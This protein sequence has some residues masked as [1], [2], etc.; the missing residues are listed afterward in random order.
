MTRRVFLQTLVWPLWFTYD[1][2]VADS[3]DYWACTSWPSV[4]NLVGLTNIAICHVAVLRTVS[5]DV[6]VSDIKLLARSGAVWVYNA[7]LSYQ[8]NTKQLQLAVTSR[9]ATCWSKLKTTSLALPVT[10]SSRWSRILPGHVDAFWLR[11]TRCVC[12]EGKVTALI[13]F[14]SPS[15]AQKRQ[16]RAFCL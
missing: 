15:N 11:L 3:A 7:A 16:S 12:K 13:A 10:I 1:I 8:W 14:I 9:H 6:T 5:L 4:L 2:S